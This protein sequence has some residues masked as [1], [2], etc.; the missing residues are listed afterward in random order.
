MEELS[1]QKVIGAVNGRLL[2]GD[3]VSVVTGVST[4]T[5]SLKP[6]DLFVALKGEQA[7]GHM[8]VRRAIELGAA[9]V[10][11]SDES[12]LPPETSAVAIKVVDPLWA[13][14]DLAKHYRSLFKVRV[15]GITGSVGKTTTKEMLT[16]ITQQRWKVLKNTANYNNEIGLPLTL[17]QLD[18]S[19]E[20]V[21]LEMAMR[22]LGEIQRLASIAKPEIG[23]ITNIGI[24]HIERLGSQGSIANAKAELLGELPP[25]GVAVLNVEDGYFEV[26]KERFK[27]K[28]V[29]FGSSK[30]A[31]V[32]GAR[33]KCQDKG[34]Y[35]FVL[36]ISGQG[37][38]EVTLPV[39]GRHNVYNALAA[40]AA[41]NQLGIDIL[42]IRD[43]LENA[44]SPDMRMEFTVSKEGYAV[45]NDA[46]NAS[47]ASVI[48]ALKTLKA[49]KG[50]DR[51]VAILG[52]MLELGDYSRKAHEDVGRELVENGIKKLIVV[53][54][55]AAGIADGARSAKMPND[56]IKS[57]KC[58]TEAAEKIKSHLRAGDAVLVK[59]SRAVKMEEIVRALLN[60]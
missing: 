18:R 43:G 23:I 8:Y 9:A 45:L 4:D 12:C 44:T 59:G 39:L 2:A 56:A 51:K 3:P 21:V 1:V 13:L 60:D 30:S 35:K 16:T 34:Q 15:V 28:V 46:Y 14:G 20:V 32:I 11:I 33:I 5:R 58:S 36:L 47:P 22:G 50:Y 52:D 38:V 54:E 31:D 40:A 41:A 48:A 53:G 25:E 19:Y 26:M 42:S 37:A 27:G 29:S 49:L 6:G 7:D 57:Y 17:F 10:L 24:S 55:L